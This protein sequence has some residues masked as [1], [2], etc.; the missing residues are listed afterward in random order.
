[1]SAESVYD[2]GSPGSAVSGG[3]TGWL[4]TAVD[5]RPG[6]P[7]VDALCEMFASVCQ[8]AVDPLEIAS[9]LEFEGVSDR[10]A[11]SLYG[12]PDVFTLAQAMYGRVPRRPAAPEPSPEP[13]PASRLRPALHG[14]L[15]GLPA[16]CFPAAGALLV[17]PGVLTALVVALL[18]AW[19]LS[20]GLACIGYLRLGT[21][22]AGQAGRVLRAG[23]IA[24]LAVVTAAM[25]AIW[26]IMHAHPLVL[27]FG[28]GEGAYM[29]GACVVMVL[30]AERWLLVALAPGVLGSAF[31]LFL[32][33]PP[34]LEH[35]A[36]GTMAATPVLACAI[37]LVRTRRIGPS[38]PSAGRLLGAA[39]LRAALPAI[40]FGVVAAG[41]LTFPVVA[42]PHGHGGL[43]VA[44][45]L[46][47]LPLSL[48]MGAAEWSM[49]WYRRRTQRLLRGTS[50]LRAFRPRARRLLLAALLQYLAGA[51]ALT[52]VAVAVASVTGLV[53][54]RWAYLPEMAAYVAL[55]S[56]MFLALLLQALRMWAFPLA[57]CA[58]ALAA[59][60]AF[61]SHGLAVQVAAPV[62]L[63]LVI[64]CHAGLALAQAVRHGF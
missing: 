43:N 8:S 34:G 51:V 63:L 64:G 19:G 18:V 36:W 58:A 61:R 44:A 20:Q 38:G 31:F 56:A 27:F 45:L 1:M 57:V 14:L 28:A 6:T 11:Q 3:S 47:S 10:M 40:G 48:S 24:G 23:L 60:I 9:A 12:Q 21:T 13:W 53:H 25:T 54:A 42:G 37:A 62:A 41:L 30:G 2:W 26:L 55:G 59:E 5:S 35:V 39:E 7:T 52:A 46:A 17:G 29:L 4:D 33:R 16:I 50:D 22:D 49:L 32:G 15:Y